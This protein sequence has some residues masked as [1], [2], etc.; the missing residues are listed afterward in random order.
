[1]KQQKKASEKK[2]KEHILVP[3]EITVGELA[4]RIKRPATELIKNLMMLGQMASVNEIIDFDTAALI[5]DD[6]GFE[7][8]LEVIVTKEDILF[9]DVEDAPEDLQPRP[10]W[11]WVTLTMVKPHFLMLSVKPPLH[12]QRQVVLRSTLVLTRLI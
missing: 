9:N 7:T 10:P 2:E 4:E 5:L 3:A 6:M 12:L 1:M 11:L 8:E